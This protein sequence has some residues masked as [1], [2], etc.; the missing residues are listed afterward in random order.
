MSN[1]RIVSLVPSATDWIAALGLADHVV[2]CTHECRLPDGRQVPVVVA[3][4][5]HH[6]AS[7]P[8]GVD[9]AVTRAAAEL[10][11]L[12]G[13]DMDLV[14]ELAPDIVV[15]QELC[16]VC[17]VSAS[18]VRQM[19]QARPGTRVVNMTG[20][21]LDGVFTDG[22][23]L[24][25]ALGVQARGTEVVAALRRRVGAVADAVRAAARPTVSFL[26]WTDPG[27][28]A[29][30]WVPDQIEAAGGRCRVGRSG[31]PSY[32]DD[33]AAFAGSDVLL[34]GPCGYDL[35][36]AAGAATALGERLPE[37]G[38]IWAVN[39]NAMWS[40][41]APAVVDGIEA[42]AGILHPD[43]MPAPGR[44]LARCLTP[45]PAVTG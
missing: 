31:Q 9:A 7:D 39:A 45:A 2:G 34:V 42:L 22:L 10:V 12:Y 3:P 33:L 30:H 44:D 37:A 32:R 24:A 8:A 17:A 29:G 36:E 15:T 41:P 40:R 6:D 43:R 25:S 11:P 4:A 1:P 13:L 18:T 38:A 16:D 26:E 5:V 23:A 21:T 19:L 27:W 20:V 28:V 35:D 14:D